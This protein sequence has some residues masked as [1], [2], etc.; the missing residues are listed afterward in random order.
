MFPEGETATHHFKR[1]GGT[2]Y[3]V[4][5]RHLPGDRVLLAMGVAKPGDTTSQIVLI[6]VAE[7]KY[8]YAAL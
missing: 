7:L 8:F 5:V 1:D 3:S 6:R 2:V 4:R